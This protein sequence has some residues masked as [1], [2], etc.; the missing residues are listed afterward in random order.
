[1]K[2]SATVADDGN[3]RPQKTDNIKMKEVFLS[4]RSNIFLDS[5][6]MGKPPIKCC[7]QIE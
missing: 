4:R 5:M 7:D 1:M 2:G 3:A 6:G